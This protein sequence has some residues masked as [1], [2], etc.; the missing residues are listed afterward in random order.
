MRPVPEGYTRLT[1]ELLIRAYSAG[2]FPMAESGAAATVFWVDPPDRGV[3]PL[4]A[5]HV[6]R[7]L[8]KT[9]RRRLFDVRCDTAF[10][11]V[12]RCCAEATRQRPD[13]WI[14]DEIIRAYS[15]LHALGCAHSVESW[16]DGRLVGGIYGV[17]LG[18][19]FFGESMFHRRT[20]AS[21]VALVHLVARLRLGGYRLFDTQFAT[22]HLGR[23]G[24]VEIPARVYLRRLADAIRG[25]ATFPAAPNPKGMD[26]ALAGVL[27]RKTKEHG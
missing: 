16:R 5:F 19:A 12:M 2:I 1:P 10:E 17:A 6:P 8:A 25:A 22:E 11:R 9:V 4:D 14:N 21:K 20:D 15:E 24:A 27:A 23:F 26:E 3:V 7:R 13:T 18:G